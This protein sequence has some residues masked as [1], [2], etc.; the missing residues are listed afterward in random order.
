ML[1]AV[2]LLLSLHG[3][4]QKVF[5]LSHIIDSVLSAHYQRA[6]IDTAYITR[7][8]TK[9]TVTGRLN[10][11]GAELQSKGTENGRH[12][13][14]MIKA[15]YKSTL[16]LG[17]SYR[18][19][20]LSMA[21]NPAKLLG[22]YHDYEFNFRTYGRRFGFDVAY[23]DAR[24]VQGWHQRADETRIT[25]PEDMLKLRTLNANAYYI[26]NHRCFSYP[27]AFAHSYVQRRS[28]G[29]VMLAVSGQGQHGETLTEK[30]A[31][32]EPLME[33]QMTNIGIGAGYGYNYVPAD[34]WLLHL[35]A[36]PTFIVYSNTS[37]TFDDTRI[38]MHYHFPEVIITG[39]GAIGRQIG[40]DKFAGISSVFTFTNIGD[41]EQLAIHNTK[42]LTRAYFGFRF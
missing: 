17:V 38:S 23:L 20:S 41:E 26:F 25:L 12:Y 5:K 8:Q 3:H 33:F 40:R 28:S 16:S 13:E 35:S 37:L 11:S 4:S 21:L 2:L 19:L 1:I 24:N 29:S 9:W 31:R 15:S 32:Q 14:S 18:G 10:V 7:P 39:R 6:D 27:A 30:L 42:W 34:G 22:K 36:L